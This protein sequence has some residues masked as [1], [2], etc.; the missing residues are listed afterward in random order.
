LV[1]ISVQGDGLRCADV[2]DVHEGGGGARTTDLLGCNG[3]G[4]MIEPESSQLFRKEHAVPPRTPERVQIVARKDPLRV[5]PFRIRTDDGLD[6][7]SDFGTE[8]F[9]IMLGH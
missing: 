6:E 1:V 5:D 4:D 9:V 7:T 2:H 3:K 8:C